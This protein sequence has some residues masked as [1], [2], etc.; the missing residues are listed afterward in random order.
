MA[1]T[2]KFAAIISLLFCQ[3]AGA[4]TL[5]IEPGI[6]VNMFSSSEANYNDGSN[7]YTGTI[8]SKDLS[9]AL[10]F[11]LHY[12]H[13][14][15]GIESELYN[16]VA[17]L[18]DDDDSTQDLALPLQLNYNS[19]FIGYEFLPHHFAYIALS[20]TPKLSSGSVSFTEDHS[21]VSFEYSYHIKAWVSFNVKWETASEFTNRSEKELDFKN[22]LLIGFSFPLNSEV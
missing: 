17:H 2:R 11:G 12:G 9:Y 1:Q 10:K 15:F 4:K 21:V 16:F 3:L 20:N 18:E 6:F 19:I 22:L 8:R 13:F 7:E 14:E 5:F